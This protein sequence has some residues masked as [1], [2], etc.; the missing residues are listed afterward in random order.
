MQGPDATDV[1]NAAT[2]APAGAPSAASMLNNIKQGGTTSAALA[3]SPPPASN[4]P[5][6]LPAPPGVSLKIGAPA[7]S[8]PAA[9]EKPI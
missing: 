7:E 6:S 9:G 3:G 5:P 8:P 1:P 2:G 4:A